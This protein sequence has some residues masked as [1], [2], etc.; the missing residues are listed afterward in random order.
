MAS[1]IHADPGIDTAQVTSEA[2]LEQ[3]IGEAYVETDA[4]PDENTDEIRDQYQAIARRHE[5]LYDQI[6]VP[7]LW[8]YEDPYESPAE[9]FERVARDQELWVFAGGSHP[10]TLT[11]IQ[12]VKGRAVHDYF[13][14]YRH[15][16]DFS[17]KGEFTVWQH[18]KQCYPPAT[19]RLLFTEIVG[20]R[21]AGGYLDN[22]F[23]DAQFIQRAFHAP[24][25]WIDLCKKVFR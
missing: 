25:S 9:L 20:Q 4:F 5:Q 2:D 14:H 6:P 23:D 24:E 21:C 7:V 15:R 13:G 3:A 18:A 19:H 8:T 11:E 22:G 17:V 1:N 16:A 12:N 10:D